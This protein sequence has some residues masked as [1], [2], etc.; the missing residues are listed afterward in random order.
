[1][2]N[3]LSF[4]L[5]ES[6]FSVLVDRFD[7]VYYSFRFASPNPEDRTPG[8]KRRSMSTENGDNHAQERVKDIPRGNDNYTSSIYGVKHLT[9]AEKEIEAGEDERDIKRRQVCFYSDVHHV[10]LD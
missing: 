4:F 10:P 9:V 6:C 8:S 2:G 7:L 3:F 5:T 1:M